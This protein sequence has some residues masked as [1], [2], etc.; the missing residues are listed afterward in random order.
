MG[1]HPSIE[2]QHLASPPRFVGRYMEVD[3]VSMEL[4]CCMSRLEQLLICGSQDCWD[5]CPGIDLE[6][7]AQHALCNILL[8]LLPRN[9]FRED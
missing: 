1:V 6:E 7:S 4:G 5:F 2:P 8:N 3:T 9:L